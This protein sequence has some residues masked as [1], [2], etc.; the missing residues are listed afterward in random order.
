M[1]NLKPLTDITEVPGKFIA[2]ALQV[3]EGTAT[4]IF[5]MVSVFILSLGLSLITN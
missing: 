5:A 4:W 1:Q 3:D 2:V